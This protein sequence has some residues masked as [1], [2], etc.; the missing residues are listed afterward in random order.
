[1]RTVIA[2]AKATTKNKTVLSDCI[3]LLILPSRRTIKTRESLLRSSRNLVSDGIF[4]CVGPG[5]N[6]LEPVG[7]L[8]IPRPERKRKGDQVRG[9]GGQGRLPSRLNCKVPTRA[10]VCS[11]SWLNSGHGHRCLQNKQAEEDE[12]IS[13]SMY[14][15]NYDGGSAAA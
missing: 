1:M 7:L 11:H 10:A 3:V 8:R 5:N 6:R 9:C 14:R 2:I 15:W 4:Q 12:G 13:K